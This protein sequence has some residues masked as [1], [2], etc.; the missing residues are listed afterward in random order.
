MP[1]GVRVQ[2]MAV[3]PRVSSRGVTIFSFM[4]VSLSFGHIYCCC[5][6]VPYKKDVS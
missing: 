4:L 5:G 3:T 2:L 6:L 1:L